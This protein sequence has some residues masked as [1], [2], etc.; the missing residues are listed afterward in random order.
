MAWP[1]DES[2][3][4]ID[5]QL[6]NESRNA[7]NRLKS[8]EDDAEFV[9]HVTQQLLPQYPVLANERCGT[10]YVDAAKTHAQQ[11]V[12]F[13]STDGHCGSWQFSLRRANTH[14]FDVLRSSQGGGCVIVDSTRSG[15]PMPDSFSRTIPIWCAVWNRACFREMQS[16]GVLNDRRRLAHWDNEVHMPPSIISESERTQVDGILDSFVDKLMASDIDV[17]AIA[18]NIAKPLRPI[19]ITRDHRLVFPPDFAEAAFTPIVCLSASSSSSSSSLSSLG[20]SVD[21]NYVQGAGDDQEMWAMGLTPR[22]FWKHRAFLLDAANTCE[23][24]IRNIVALNDDD[25]DEGV[26]SDCARF[27]FIA[28]TQVAVGDRVSGR[29]PECWNNFDAI[30]NCGAPPYAEHSVQD[31][32][33]ALRY[34]YLPIPEGKRGQA[35]LGNQIPRALAFVLPFLRVPGKRVLVHCSQGMDRSAGIALAIMTRFFDKHRMFCEDRIEEKEDPGA[36]TKEGILNRLLWITTSHQKANPSRAT[37]K[38]MLGQPPPATTTTTSSPVMFERAMTVMQ[39]EWRRFEQE[40]ASWDVERIKF[41]ARISAMEKRIAH[42]S[43]LY[44]ASQKHI[45]IL[46]AVLKRDAETMSRKGKPR[47][48][49][50]LLLSSEKEEKE[51]EE[52][53]EEHLTNGNSG[54]SATVANLVEATASTRERSKQLLSR[55]LQEIDVL[56]TNS[57]ASAM[58]VR[59]QPQVQ[60]SNASSI[61]SLWKHPDAM[62]GNESSL[63]RSIIESEQLGDEPLAARFP[64]IA[65]TAE[66]VVGDTR[67]KRVRGVSE[68]P[69]PPPPPLLLSQ[70]AAAAVPVSR[71][72]PIAA[73]PGS[74]HPTAIDDTNKMLTVD[75]VDDNAR[76]SENSNGMAGGEWTATKTFI[77]HMDIVRTVCV[78]M[79]N[80]DASGKAS[81]QQQQQQLLTGS[82]DGMLMLWDV[83][84]DEQRRRASA[85][86]SSRLRRQ[87]Q[88]PQ[89]L[90]QWQREANSGNAGGDVVNGPA[91]IF[92]GHLAGITSVVSSSTQPLAYSGS[93]DS[94]IGVWRIHGSGG[95]GNDTFAAGELVGHTDAVWD[96]SL[97]A[98]ASLLASVS[99]DATCKLWN[100]SGKDSSNGS[101][102]S[103]LTYMRDK[104]VVPTSVCFTAADGA[105]LA[106]GYA[107]GRIETYDTQHGSSALIQATDASRIMANTRI[108]KVVCRP[109]ESEHVVGAACADGSVHL[110]DM[111]SGKTVLSPASG[112][113]A[114]PQRG[115]AATAVDLW[116]GNGAMALVVTGGSDGVV[117]WWDWRR[118][119]ASV[120]ETRAHQR[121]GDE[122]VCA[123]C[124][125]PPNANA[126]AMMV[127]SAGADGSA[128]LFRN[129]QQ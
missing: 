53:M 7:Y 56:M 54:T 66:V 19:W 79:D 14:L 73:M 21:F 46:E 36:V 129:T 92:R 25:V 93:L 67:Q 12:Y 118:A 28:G 126:S 9:G 82:D 31:E 8:I 35:E 94:R 80:N 115:I 16:S 120:H 13:K 17:S 102:A 55:C 75:E 81:Q 69:P 110:F 119:L 38:Q 3:S 101:N 113:A 48:V 98:R 123:V 39:S 77:G 90:L 83:E 34:I 60:Q 121:K 26:S 122:G 128:K 71:Q 125:V 47:P 43:A 37:L 64:S 78:R 107:D 84:A 103:A 112:I 72:Q 30:I 105:R 95:A 22:M 23:R 40:R 20:Q 114:Y 99:A 2:K 52:E 96:L 4:L 50:P 61:L 29:P 10:W 51:K 33:L 63:T 104:R 91:A 1:I 24:R 106:I 59:K 11:T 42:L 32:N 108:T 68:P 89:E 76:S 117:R 116:K 86:S 6:R 18:A 74:S 70:A 44:G 57:G 85:S 97:N 45:T 87:S 15:K 27:H 109:E 100:T 127:A 49:E 65:A 58:D 88:R 124:V 5:R 62:D 41:K 111:R